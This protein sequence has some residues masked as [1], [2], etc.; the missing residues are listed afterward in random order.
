MSR[1]PWP[2]TIEF[3]AKAMPGASDEFLNLPA[4]LV[5]RGG[6]A[7]LADPWWLSHTSAQDGLEASG[8]QLP[9]PL[10]AHPGKAFHPRRRGHAGVTQQVRDTHSDAIGI[11][12]RPAI[13]GFAVEDGIGGTARVPADH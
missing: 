8:G 10:P 11:A 9:A 4:L 6:L 2:V 13:A 7:C 1:P 3:R 12:P 5:L